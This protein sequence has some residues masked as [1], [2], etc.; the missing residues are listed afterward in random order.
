MHPVLII[1]GFLAPTATNLV[2]K[3]RLKADGFLAEDVPLEGLNA[4]DIRDSARIVEMSVNAM[5]TRAQVK[6]VDLIGISMGGLIGLH[7]LRKLGGDAYV[8]RFIT[9]GTPFHGTHLARWMRLLTLG[10]ATGAEQ[11][12][13][14]SDFLKEL[15]AHDAEHQAEIYSLHTSADAF[16]SEEAAALKGARLVKSPHGVWP[17]GHYTPLFLPQDYSLIKEILVKGEGA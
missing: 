14:G 16:V 2:L 9:I 5:R 8:R 7:Y 17:A 10:R 13:P 6:K 3:T 1:Q 15:H 11:M 12:I 4:G